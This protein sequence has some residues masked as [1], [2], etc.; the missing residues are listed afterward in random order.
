MP[1][2]SRVLL[3]I[4]IAQWALTVFPLQAIETHMNTTKKNKK[5]QPMPFDFT[6]FEQEIAA[7]MILDIRYFCQGTTEKP[8]DKKCWQPVKVLPLA[9]SRMITETNIGGIVLFAENMANTQQVVQ[10]THDIQLAALKSV[11]AKPIIISV[12]QEGGR[13]ARFAKMTGFAGNMAIGATFEK[14]GVLFSTQVNTV[15]GK[16]LKALGIN[17]NYAPVVDVNTNASNPVINTRSY[18]ENAVN[19]GK[20]G[21]ASVDALQ[22]EGVMA[23]LK[24]FPGHGDTHVDSHLGLPRVDHDLATIEQVDL[25]P[26]ILA[27]AQ[28]Q[29]A[30]IMT[31]H[32]QYPTLDQSTFTAKSGEQVI[33]P[34]TMSKKIL[35]DLLRN[36][37]AFDG[38][39]VTDALDMAGISHYFT[40]VEAVVETFI[41]GAD[42]AV[43]PFKI[44]NSNDIIA[45]KAFITAV[46]QTLYARITERETRS[47]LADLNAI[48]YTLTDFERSIARLDRYKKLYI[49]LSNTSVAA[50]YKI[51]QT[52][53]AKTEHLAIEQDLAN[54]AVTL[55]HGDI[56]QLK[57][58]LEL[59]SNS[60]SDKVITKKSTVKKLHIL[61]ANE[62]ELSAFQYALEQ[63]LVSI[64]EKYHPEISWLVAGERVTQS[65]HDAL[66]A[67]ADLFIATIDVKTASLVDIG[68]MDDLA[69]VTTKVYGND[70]TTKQN[71]TYGKFLKVALTRAKAHKTMRVLIAKGSPY[72]LK[73]FTK[74][75]DVILLTF[76]DRIYSL[77]EGSLVIENDNN[78]VE[79]GLIS[80]GFNATVAVIFSQQPIEGRLPVSL[81][82]E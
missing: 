37:M 67:Q 17:N 81:N 12:D 18:G 7:K 13:V 42:I 31:A 9:L 20:L 3:L 45:F 66:I 14:Y 26:F 78:K 36:K 79:K 59:S 55:L 61:V 38:L 65:A 77:T 54:A 29:P 50:Q 28:T 4:I 40:E 74:I 43:M 10:L 22:A 33:R 58:L 51:A 44:R 80:P 6:R 39:I 53:I 62:Q 21:V 46:A 34:A 27:I 11:S 47:G 41:A 75:V 35:T 69:S 48:T 63:T 24:H 68:G 19:V 73:D 72:L 71:Y 15:L 32:I 23:T 2:L 25:A 76:D 8:T 60:L 82:V 70:V 56:A 57:G 49:T 30:M 1:T 64:P 16:E 5:K 52:V